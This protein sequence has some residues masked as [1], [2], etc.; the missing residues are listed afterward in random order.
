MLF[1]LGGGS[2]H[3]VAICFGHPTNDKMTWKAKLPGSF[4]GGKIRD[5]IFV[6]FVG[7]DLRWNRI[8][9]SEDIEL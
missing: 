9:L 1:N 7:F 8:F 3:R 2:I 6:E 4:K 5:C